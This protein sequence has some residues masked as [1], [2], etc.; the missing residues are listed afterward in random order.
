MV[1]DTR[2]RLHCEDI[3]VLGLAKGTTRRGLVNHQEALEKT[4]VKY[5]DYINI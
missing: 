1:E 4:Y 3:R 5:V 2:E